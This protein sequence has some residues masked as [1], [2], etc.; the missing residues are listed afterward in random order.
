MRRFLATSLIAL[1][2]VIGATSAAPVAHA[3]NCTVLGQGCVT[4]GT[5]SVVGTCQATPPG[6][7]KTM[8][9]VASA[10]DN[11]SVGNTAPV[12]TPTAS[13][14]NTGAA[15]P[16]DPDLS[17]GFG[18]IMTWVMSLFAWL[19]GVAALLLDY[20]VYFTVV[21][22]GNY[23][24][25]LSAIGVAWRVLRD[26]ANIMLIFGFLAIGI[27]TIM[28]VDWYGD[29]KKLLPKLV[30]AAVLLNFSLFVCEAMIDGTNLIATQFYQQIS[31]GSLP[32]MSGTG[33]TGLAVNGT[34]LNTANEPI[35][36]AIMGQL[37]LQTIYNV[38]GNPEALKGGHTWFIGFMGI[39][40]FIITAFVLFS[41]AFILIARFV[42][43]IFYILLSPI[44]FMGW[45]L[46]LM[47][48][49]ADQWWKNFLAQII[50]APVLLLLLYVALTVITDAKFLTGF[51]SSSD[52]WLG[53]VNST[54]IVGFAG[55]LLSFT[56]AIGL[57]LVVVIK[58]KSM[59]AFGADFATKTAGKL[60]FG[61]TALGL[62]TTAGLGFQSA[63]Q[64]LRRSKYR[65]TKTA[66][67]LASGLDKGAQG[68]FDIRGTNFLKSFPGSGID[69]GA[70][71]KG[72]YRGRQDRAIKAHETY[73]G[74]LQE[75]KNQTKEEEEQI[76]KAT[77]E[78]EKAMAEQDTV[79]TA[80]EIAAKD[81]ETKKAE[82]ERL[83]DMEKKNPGS[84]TSGLIA[85]R[86]NLV[87]SEASLKTVSANLV[88]ATE[89]LTGAMKA[90]IETKEGV[91]SARSK[92]GVQK[93]YA[94][95]IENSPIKSWALFGPGGSA[96]AEKIKRAAKEKSQGDK[97]NDMIKEAAKTEAEKMT[98]QAPVAASAPA[99][100]KS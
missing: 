83:E 91:K 55:M 24:H 48:Y 92:K 45:A 23:V 74:S 47:Q 14:T 88:Q 61:A 10:V 85:A 100:N 86:Q 95:N 51:N 58:A 89:K 28:Q 15:T 90:E 77:A 93:A 82:M 52:G 96:A 40:L 69:A 46:P 66:R 70:A 41:L 3:D 44:G 34:N 42:A 72:G 29:S 22:M 19:V 71:A 18:T 5:P 39:I 7:V 36:N 49:R 87:S 43:L 25:N 6:S 4:D 12:I 64:A 20:A 17:G 65:A 59:S 2:V 35:S 21:T 81:L 33:M 78:K 32:T 60:T 80:H 54:N 56:V 79:K 75:R 37:G 76:A 50:T 62:R 68:S 27:T 94:E 53:L 16:T 9:C 8:V 26:A 13:S 57:L 1:A 11:G 30:V 97:I 73:A 84:A 63:S 67:I 31:G 99:P 98:K 38:K